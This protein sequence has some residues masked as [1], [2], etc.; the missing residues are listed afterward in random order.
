MVRDHAAEYG[1]L[2]R[3]VAVVIRGVDQVE[4]RRAG[5]C[6]PQVGAVAHGAVGGEEL[7]T[8]GDGLRVP[9][10]RRGSSVATG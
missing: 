3:L 1:A 2:E 9:G 4:K 7:G 6:A 10:A 8:G 5:R